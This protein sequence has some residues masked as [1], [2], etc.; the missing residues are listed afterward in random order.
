[1]NFPFLKAKERL[2]RIMGTFDLATGHAETFD[3][4]LD[5]LESELRDVLGHYR[6]ALSQTEQDVV[7]GLVLKQGPDYERGF[8]DGMQKQMQ[9]SVDK[10]V[11]AMAQPKQ[12]EPVCPEC[13]A[14]VLYECVACSSNNYPPQRTWVGLTDEERD[15]IT[16]KVIGFNSCV[17]WEED[18]AKAI[19]AKLKEKNNG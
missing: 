8:V 13:K 17:G 19:E 18:Y 14:G 16:G 7:G 2:I 12:G 3:E 10:A 15:A 5:S 4:L 6:E 9:S 11:N 1:M